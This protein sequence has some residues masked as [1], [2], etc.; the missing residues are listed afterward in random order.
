MNIGVLFDLD[1]VVI[2]SES[3]Y[4]N[5]WIDIEKIFPTGIENFALKIKGSTLPTILNTYYPDEEKQAVIMSRIVDFEKNMQYRPF[6]EALRFIRELKEA[7]IRC[8]IVTSS[9]QNKMNNLYLQNPGFK[10]LFDAV[11]TGDV[12]T[13]SKPHPEPYL[14][15]ASAIGIQPENCY[16]FEDSLSGIQSGLNANATVIGLATTLPYSQID[17]KA[18]KTIHDFTGFS[19]SD[20]LSVKKAF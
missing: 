16:V 13:H 10:E 19:I 18:H 4:T 8:A 20:M 7:G 1:G 3:I 17:G 6:P 9:S 11:I 5:F 15:G 2:D 12:V 14:M